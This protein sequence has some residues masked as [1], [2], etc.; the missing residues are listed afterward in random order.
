MTIVTLNG[1]R[2]ILAYW[3]GIPVVIVNTDQTTVL[4]LLEDKDTE[5]AVITGDNQRPTV[6]AKELQIA[7]A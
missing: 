2:G 4:H 1:E 5:V 6:R 3:R 7:V